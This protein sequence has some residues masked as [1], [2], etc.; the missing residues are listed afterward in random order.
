MRR[1]P[2]LSIFVMN[3]GGHEYMFAGSHRVLH[4]GP[5]PGRHRGLGAHRGHPGRP[6][7]RRAQRHA[8]HARHRG[9]AARPDGPPRRRA[10]AAADGFKGVSGLR[11]AHGSAAPGRR[12]PP[13][14]P[15]SATP[16]P[17]PCWACTAGFTPSTTRWTAW[18]PGSS[19]RCCSAHQRTLERLVEPVESPGR[20]GRRR[21]R[22][23]SP[24]HG[25]A[26][27]RVTDR[28]LRDS[29][30]AWGRRNGRGLS[31]ARHETQT[32][33]RPSRSCPRS[34]PAI[35]SACDAS[36]AKRAP[37]DDQSSPRRQSSA[38]RRSRRP[39]LRT[40][41]GRSACFGA[42]RG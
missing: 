28:V 3:T 1:F 38:S 29:G 25:R 40:R 20:P 12:A 19:P 6:R 42:G 35:P 37:G 8:G 39:T 27:I 2:T 15:T 30:A 32:R 14:S 10:A 9:S 31:V 26:P 22:C 34:S 41:T 17:L 33:G 24:A 16:R 5:A 23:N 13:P 11:A 36:A 7:R 18:T 21:L 4:R